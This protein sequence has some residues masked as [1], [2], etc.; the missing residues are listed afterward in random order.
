M[1]SRIAEQRQRLILN[2]AERYLE[3]GEP[4]LHWVRARQAEGRR[5]GF[6]FLTERRCIVH[7]TGR[8]DGIPGDFP[9]DEIAN[10]G[11]ASDTSGGPILAIESGGEQCFVQLRATTPAMA[12]EV[13]IFVTHFAERAP[14]PLQTVEGADHLGTFEPKQALEVSTHKMSITDHTR[15]IIV[16][17]LG[18]ALIFS[19]I[20]I[21]PL[22]GPWS[23][24]VT[25]AGL[26]ILASEYDWARDAMEWTKQRY[27]A[28][29]DK[30][31]ARR[32]ST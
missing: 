21:I 29:A 31:K 18:V 16:T 27:K 11:I 10:W 25:I 13:A 9:W 4:V 20:V 32:R 14:E 19:A 8:A 17:V 6:V 28:A 5:E 12:E 24:I 23:F 2:Q 3:D 30:L 7:W 26:A 15:R 1:L 22:P